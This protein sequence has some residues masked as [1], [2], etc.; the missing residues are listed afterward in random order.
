[1][2][3]GRYADGIPQT[4]DSEAVLRPSNIDELGPG[5]D[6]SFLLGGWS[7]D[8]LGFVYACPIMIGSPPPLGPVCGN[9]F[10]AETPVAFGEGARVLLDGWT[11]DIPAGPVVLRVHVNDPLATRCAPA[12]REAC[13]AM[14]VIEAVVW[15]GDHV[16]A[17]APLTPIEAMSRLAGAD[18]DLTQATITPIGRPSPDVLAQPTNA[19]DATGI[20]RG[21]PTASCEPPF[22][23]MTWSVVGSSISLVLVFPSMAGREA[24][25]SKFHASGFEGIG[26]CWIITDSYFNHEWVAVQNVMVAALMNADGPTAAQAKL[27]QD[28][29]EALQMR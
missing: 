19:P 21:G 28:V 24:V 7:F 25:Q 3:E 9:Q 27:V 5:D 14:A 11:P 23:P 26:G 10:L 15:T 29:R 12:M 6:R 4:I 17:A 13:A 18:P 22:P 16:T 20:T 2:I 1:V 8:F